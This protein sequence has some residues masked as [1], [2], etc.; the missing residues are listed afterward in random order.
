MLLA[1]THNPHVAPEPPLKRSDRRLL[2]YHA[3]SDRWSAFNAH[4]A[5][6]VSAWYA[7]DVEVLDS[8]TGETVVRGREHVRA[9]F[10]AFFRE[11]PEVAIDADKRVYEEGGR[12]VRDREIVT[13]CGDVALQSWVKY[14]FAPVG[15]RITRVWVSRF[16]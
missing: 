8:A 10:A 1:C 11:H 4:D 9:R 15:R 6:Q 12:F 3:L 7:E 14:E 2:A 5:D 16:P 13:G